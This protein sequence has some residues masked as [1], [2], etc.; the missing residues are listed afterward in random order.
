MARVIS[1]RKQ[2]EKR[3]RLRVAASLMDFV[4]VVGCLVIIALCVALFRSLSA[5]I[6]G[7]FEATFAKL[8]ETVRS[9]VLV[10]GK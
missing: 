1:R 5:W 3:I 7:D 8:E 6:S 4:G 9:A 10:T 2:R